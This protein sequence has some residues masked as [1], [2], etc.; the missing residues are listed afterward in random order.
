MFKIFSPKEPQSQKILCCFVLVALFALLGLEY[1]S[2]FDHEKW[3]KYQ[4]EGTLCM[5]EGKL[6]EADSLLMLAAEV[7][8]QL[9]AA[10]SGDRYYSSLHNLGEVYRK[11]GKLAQADSIYIQTVEFFS[12]SR[13]LEDKET[14]AVYSSYAMLKYEQGEYSKADSLFLTVLPAD[15]K[16]IGLDDPESEETMSVLTKDDIDPYSDLVN[17]YV[18][19][20]FTLEMLGKCSIARNLPDDAHEYFRRAYEIRHRMIPEDHP[21]N[22]QLIKL[23]EETE[24]GHSDKIE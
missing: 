12:E 1:P 23:I 22:Q 8:R 24:V 19:L 5:F 20:S 11:Q 3:L 2:S 14:R 4:R 13:G 16:A 21:L 18:N 10:D 9:D 7:G 15:I 6:A 17:N